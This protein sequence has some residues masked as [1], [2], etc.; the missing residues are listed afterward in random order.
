MDLDVVGSA[1]RGEVLLLHGLEG[2]SASGYVRRCARLLAERGIRAVALNFRSRSGE[3]NR[4]R[5]FYHS[6]HTA[7][8]AHALEWLARR[9]PGAPRAAIGFSLGGNV[10][11]KLLAE[12][13]ERSPG[14]LR[15]A[16]AVSVP[17]D[18]AAAATTLERGA[19]R[20]Y[21][22]FFLRS[23][24]RTLRAKARRFPGVYDLAAA[25]AARTLR[26]FDDAITAPVHGFRSAADYYAR[27]SSGPMLGEIRVPTLVLH[28][29]DDPFLPDDAV[30]RA[31]IAEN[32]CLVDG[33]T[34]RGGHLGFVATGRQGEPR[35]WAE[36]RAVRF[37]CD[38][39]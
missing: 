39:L 28:A 37:V 3:P 5:R 17:F 11:L 35:L 14:E 26:E 7:D 9:S 34:A 25:E 36:E 4:T 38:A 27:S 21:A 16:A 24:R 30:P 15:A 12:S 22:A 2:S 8:A 6:G 13:G 33:V 19:G 18:L 10:L 1:E 29:L 32:P 23:L 31:A 20:L